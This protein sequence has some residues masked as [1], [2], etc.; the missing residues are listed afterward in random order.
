MQIHVQAPLAYVAPQTTATGSEAAQTVP[1][2][3]SGFGQLLVHWM[4]AAQ[5]ADSASKG[6]QNIHLPFPIAALML[7][8]TAPAEGWED[9]AR[10]LE[11]LRMGLDA[12]GEWPQEWRDNG[13]L[14]A[15]LDQVI[16][17][18][19]ALVN[20]GTRENGLQTPRQD[21]VAV[22]ESGS[23]SVHLAAR[24]ALESLRQLQAALSGTRATTEGTTAAVGKAAESLETVLHAL[25]SPNRSSAVSS[26]TD[27]KQ[28]AAALSF[29]HVLTASTAL[30]SDAE[31]MPVPLAQRPAAVLTAAL[32]TGITVDVNR[33]TGANPAVVSTF[34]G[35]AATAAQPSAAGQLPVA[36]IDSMTA[37]QPQP[38]AAF[39]GLQAPA[40]T[41][42]APPA[43][44]QEVPV[45]HAQRFAE[46]AGRVLLKSMKFAVADGVSEARLS[47][48]PEQ[49]GQVQVKITVSNGQL[50]AQFVAETAMGKEAIESQL[51][52]LRIALQNQG[53][54][55]EK[56]EVTHHDAFQAAHTFQDQH[57]RHAH[58]TPE[59]TRT[60]AIAG[61]DEAGEWELDES[62]ASMTSMTVGRV[63]GSSFEATA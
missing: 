57:Q 52:Q 25:A 15:L 56:L 54:Q 59:R 37:E 62:G 51:P 31:A 10:L 41:K 47:L 5:P 16:A 6:T 13:E 33:T 3:A 17:Q 4:S 11:F 44:R 48:Y 2:G 20:A 60:E 55:V 38:A 14:T 40:D 39:H 29:R 26:A 9:A 24:Q 12:N 53:I 22:G 45:V 36:A 50:V 58:Y 43:V 30:V 1:A 18:L 49:L 28:Q 42:S 27:G 32:E 23:D 63:M 7:P 19:A 35:N 61:Y 21:A 8:Q 46:E 34:D